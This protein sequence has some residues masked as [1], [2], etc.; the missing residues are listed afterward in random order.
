MHDEAVIGLKDAVRKAA[1]QAET[2]WNK[3]LDADDIEQ[4][5]WVFILESK[6]VQATLSALDDENKVARLKKK[7]DS[8]CSREKLDYERFTG[9]FLYTPADVRRILSRLAGDERI[10]D[11]EAIDFGIGFEALEDEHFHYY[12]AVRDFYFLG[13]K[14]KNKS[15]EHLKRRCVDKLAELM[16]RKRSKREADRTEG[17]GTKHQEDEEWVD[18]YE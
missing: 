16:N 13:R 1:Q 11:D 8:I 5:L 3:L 15:D 2:R 4:E 7:A 17:L 12:E 6:A 10:L 14:V 9:N 18:V